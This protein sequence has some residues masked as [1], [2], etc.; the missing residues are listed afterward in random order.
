MKTKTSYTIDEELIPQIKKTAKKE[1]R[2]ESFVVN[3]ILK[4][5][6]SKQVKG[7][8]NER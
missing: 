4:E 5:F 2:S 6:F 8:E 7:G 3:K 1:E